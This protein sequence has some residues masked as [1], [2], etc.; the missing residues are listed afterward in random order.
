MKQ[1]KYSELNDIMKVE[2]IQ[3]IKIKIFV[4]K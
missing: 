1:I 4:M 3:F 2:F